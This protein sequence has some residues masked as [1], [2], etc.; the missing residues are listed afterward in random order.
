MTSGRLTIKLKKYFLVVRNISYRAK[1]YFLPVRLFQHLRTE[2]CP[3]PSVTGPVPIAING[4]LPGA[5]TWISPTKKAHWKPTQTAAFQFSTIC[6]S[7]SNS[8]I[9]GTKSQAV[10]DPHHPTI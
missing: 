1:K 3:R 10:V 2:I 7:D 5:S 8:L 4:N 9:H 6:G